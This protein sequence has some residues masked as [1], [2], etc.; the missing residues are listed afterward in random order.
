MPKKTERGDLLGFFNIHSV[1]KH[2][3]SHYDS[4][5]SLHEVP[6]K[7][8]SVRDSNSRTPTENP[9]REQPLARQPFANKISR[10]TNSRLL[11]KRA[12]E[13]PSAM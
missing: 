9:K 4:R 2:Q 7:N 1:A 6:T 12:C 8:C 13:Q 3:K 11:G 5:V 10:R